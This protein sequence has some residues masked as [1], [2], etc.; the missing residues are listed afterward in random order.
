M[1]KLTPMLQ[2]YQQ[3]KEQHQDAIL[4]F[5]LGDFY[6]MFF[7][8]AELAARELEITLTSREAG[9]DTRAPMCGVPYHAVDSYIVRLIDKGFKV[10]ICEQVEDPKAAKG[11]VKREVVRIVTP[12]TIID[13]QA[14]TDKMNNYL[15]AVICQDGACGL[16]AA[17]VS[18][19]EFFVTGFTGPAVE[20]RLTDE[21]IRLRPTEII[22]SRQQK[23]ALAKALLRYQLRP[24]FTVQDPI[25]EDEAGCTDIL[26][27]HFSAENCVQVQQTC[28]KEAI[29][30]AGMLLHYLIQT[31][32]SEMV[33]I[34]AITPYETQ[35]YMILDGTTRRNLELTRSVRD[36]SRYGTLLDILDYTRT[37]MGGRLLRQWIEQPL[38]HKKTIEERLNSVDELMRDVTLRKE[39]QQS[40]Q[41][42]YD[43]ERLIGRL[44]YGSANARDVLALKN[45][46][47]MLPNLQHALAAVQAPQLQEICAELQP[48]TDVTSYIDKAIHPEPPFSLR[49][50]N[51]IKAGFNEMLDDLRKASK[52][53]KGWLAQMEN[54]ERE[55]TG[56]RSLKISYNKVFGYYIEITR[57][58]LHAVPEYFIRKQTLANAERFITPE[59]KKYEDLILGAEEKS[60]QLEYQLFTEVR[61]FLVGQIRRMQSV[62]RTIAKL[63]VYVSLAEC[64]ARNGYVRPQISMDY[65]LNI[66]DGRHPVVEK[67]L[68]DDLFVPNDTVLNDTD[69]K[70]VIIT[71]P[72]MAGKSTYMRQVALIVLMAQMGSFVPA[73]AA[74]VG[75]VDRIF[76]RVGANDDL[77]T[78]QSTFMVEMKE[79]ADILAHAT[80]HSLLVFDE[81]GRGTSTYDGMSIAHSVVEYTH[82]NIGAKTLFATHYHELTHLEGVLPYVKNYSVAVK[83]Q[84]DTVVFLRRIVRGGA[85][86]SYG[87]HVAQLAGLPADVI[88][89]A[90]EL[91]VQ[92]E[93]QE[94]AVSTQDKQPER[95]P[96]VHDPAP[97]DL[98]SLE[99]QI[100][101]QLSSLDVLS[102][103]PIEALNLLYKLQKKLR[104]EEV[105]TD[106]RPYSNFG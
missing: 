55:K 105:D 7:E 71:G 78:G 33:H 69:Q 4:F 30:A 27:R 25:S 50:G 101:Q 10:A 77:A 62:A 88:E 68:T 2:Q 59:L 3:V 99:Q 32:K 84:G 52:E 22:I 43:L 90:Q 13:R 65:A 57:A 67:L 11:I 24:V 35:N 85:D 63:D 49:D 34:K 21:L 96:A 104:G 45:S 79:V 91:L 89:R 102:M 23:S 46:L 103:T 76:T 93:N 42:I 17:D 53:G 95:Q 72:N 40:L 87:I 39:L 61:E 20:A 83:E 38:V 18:T 16:A 64:A 19:G 5:R 26:S 15:A 44:S 94:T 100:I 12:G 75:L 60:I 6:E 80:A 14:L 66:T 73:K 29:I 41:E 106:A 81:I 31:Q 37:A 92:L 74:S 48:L 98:F 56:I 58:N 28:E 70:I 54:S 9:G 8:D 36:G 1:A 97:I 82:N 86:R 51:I 47:L